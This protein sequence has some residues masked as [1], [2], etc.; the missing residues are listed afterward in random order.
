VEP[1]PEE[2]LQPWARTVPAAVA[3]KVTM[4]LRLEKLTMRPLRPIVIVNLED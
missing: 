1:P 2:E 4:N 3:P